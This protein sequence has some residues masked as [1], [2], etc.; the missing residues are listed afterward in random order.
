MS[1]DPQ[2][3]HRLNAGP[4]AG[5]K[6]IP[7][8]T[9]TL[10]LL[11]SFLYFTLCMDR[12]VN[13]YDEG[14][15]L[16]GANRVM[17]GDIPHRDFYTNYGPAQF[18]IIAAL[19][20]MFGP[21]VLIERCWDTI[22]RSVLAALVF[23]V[24]DRFTPRRLAVLASAASV[25]WL[26]YLGYY[27]YTAFAALA[28]SIASLLFLIPAPASP[29]SKLGPIF[30]GGC[31]G[32]AALFRYDVG[33][34]VFASG[35][36][37]LVLGKLVSQAKADR[38]GWVPLIRELSLFSLGFGVV[39]APAAILFTIHGAIPDLIFDAFI[40]P[41]KFYA[42]TRALPFP[43]LA[44]LQIWPMDFSIYIPLLV[45]VAAA[46]TLV[47][48][49]VTTAPRQRKPSLLLPIT[50]LLLL[51]AVFFAKGAVR[52][53]P[54][55]MSMALIASLIL[56]SILAQPV[57]A[58]RFASRSLVG[59]AVL[60]MAIYTFLCSID[61]LHR[62]VQNVAWAARPSTWQIAATWPPP[63]E[64]ACRVPAGL[65]RLACFRVPPETAETIRYV[66]GHTTAEQPIFVGL[67]RHD[68]ILANDVLLYFAVNRQSATKWHHFDP[69]LQ[70]SFP[71]QQEMVQELKRTKP[72][73][74]VLEAKW[75]NAHE[76][77]D[78]A[79]SSGVTLLDDYLKKSFVTIATFG[80]NTILQP[81]N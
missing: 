33:A 48:T 38:A 9:I 64:G 6:S 74:I 40:F 21:S 39:I 65:Q 23:A 52:V 10:I 28:A 46:S 25:T 5:R 26:G 73:L 61:G 36:A 32:I 66:Q 45:V 57:P 55:Q 68:K 19:F 72:K 22:V 17:D 4:A 71:I 67:S 50:A 7:M 12:N 31:M 3:N 8:K 30:A 34:A 16:F 78:S 81:A 43:T 2:G 1:D 49:M 56:V 77:N 41:A 35:C 11:V 80:P 20:K 29:G 62:A 51:T 15:I 58:R 37:I 54:I 47:D 63:P 53:T 44:S 76:P 70:T 13:P 27:G 69:G 60:L 14:I 42:K 75:A 59:A 24:A 18:Y 79:N